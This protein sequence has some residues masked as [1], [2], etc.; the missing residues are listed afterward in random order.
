MVPEYRLRGQLLNP[1]STRFVGR[2]VTHP[3]KP[4]MHPTP[5]WLM[6]GADSNADKTYRAVR[7]RQTVH[8]RF[9]LFFSQTNVANVKVIEPR[10]KPL[11]PAIQMSHVTFSKTAVISPIPSSIPS[12]VAQSPKRVSPRP[13]K[14]SL[15]VNLI[16]TDQNVAPDSRSEVDLCLEVEFNANQ[17]RSILEVA[18]LVDWAL[19]EVP[20]DAVSDGSF[21]ARAR[22]AGEVSPTAPLGGPDSPGIGRWC[23]WPR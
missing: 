12:Q 13:E 22:D 16:K 20:W 14:S 6:K 10:A 17:Q 5:R 18:V 7:I 15:R 9:C 8:S 11:G 19:E 4:P 21:C 1:T 2:Q 3:R 23:G